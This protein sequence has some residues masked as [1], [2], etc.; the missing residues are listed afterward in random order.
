MYTCAPMYPGPVS[1][2]PEAL[3]ALSL[4]YLPARYNSEYEFAYKYVCTSIQKICNTKNDIVI[5]TGEGMLALWT[6]LKSTLK[7]QDRVLT[8]GTGLFGDGF[9]DMARAINCEVQQVSFP[10]DAT[11]TEEN[12]KEIEKVIDSFKPKMITLIHCETPSG[13]LNPLEGIGALKKKM[14][15]PLFVVDAVASMGGA[16]INADDCN[17]DLL[18]GASQKCFSCPAD[19]AILAVSPNAWKIIDEVNYIGYEALKPFMNIAYDAKK[20]PYTPHAHGIFALSASLKAM[21]FEGYDNVYKRHDEVAQMCREG[22]QKIGLKLFPQENAISSPTVTAVY[23]PEGIN[24]AKMHTEI[25]ENGVFLG[26]SLGKLEN[27]IF[28]IGHMGTQA[29]KV[30]MNR[31][32]EVLSTYFNKI[33]N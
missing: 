14:N 21:E 7:P 31:V 22:V 16:P 29:D 33:N 23:L 10:Y 19:L 17:I 4:D 13:T 15:V 12:L 26:G 25:K 30:L 9:G 11:I 20:Y 5:H 27:K 2:H 6:A 3:K 24:W 1:V 18:L 8:I 32:L 28:R